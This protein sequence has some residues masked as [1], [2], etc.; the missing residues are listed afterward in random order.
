MA[1]GQ[2][3]VDT[4]GSAVIR[5]APV[6]CADENKA[7]DFMEALRWGDEKIH[8]CPRCGDCDVYTVVDRKTPKKRNVDY[9]WRCRACGRYHTI[10]TRTVMED[11]RIPLRHWC[12]AFWK[13]CSC[14]KGISAMQIHR[15]TGLSYKSALF[16]MHLIRFALSDMP[17]CKL[18][19]TVEVDETYV[20][21]K[22]RR[23]GLVSKRGRGTRKQ[24]VIALVQRGGDVRARVIPNVTAKTLKAAI[25]EHVDPTARI[26]T[27]EFGSYRSLGS[28]WPGGHEVVFQRK[29]EYSRG[30]AH[31][32]TAESFFAILKRGIYGTFHAVSKRHLH[33][34]ASE[35]EFRWNN[36]KMDDGERVIRA[37]RASEGKRLLYRKPLVL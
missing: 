9:R 30:S 2:S 25:S 20:G 15:E 1:K 17:G 21:G 22:P 35:F 27:D 32:N 10:R 26:N 37:V 34:Y 8:A 7:V 14:K 29:G 19:Y 6:T 13:A 11:S 4:S 12:Y 16:L 5:N 3:K 24:P 18:T 23:C 28:N 36:R 33:R 31:T